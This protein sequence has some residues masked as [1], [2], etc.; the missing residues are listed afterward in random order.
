MTKYLFLL[1]FL[2]S[3]SFNQES[4]IQMKYSIKKDEL[5][6]NLGGQHERSI[7]YYGKITI[8]SAIEDVTTTRRVLAHELGHFEM[9]LGFSIENEG[10]Q[11]LF[12]E[13]FAQML[14]NNQKPLEAIESAVTYCNENKIKFTKKDR[15]TA[16]YL[17]LAYY[18]EKATIE[19][20]KQTIKE[21][22]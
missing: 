22:E 12:A 16:Y 10:L 9:C 6:D 20:H 19:K 8:N 17:L 1:I 18:T 3:C 15:T 21:Y 7:N 14:I 5:P 2:C 4:G 11:E 13:G